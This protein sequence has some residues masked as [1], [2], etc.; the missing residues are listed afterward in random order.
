MTG[1]IVCYRVSALVHRNLPWYK[2]KTLGLP[3]HFSSII[4]SLYNQVQGKA[5]VNN[6]FTDWFPIESGVKRG[7]LLFPL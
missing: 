6:S 5:R 2:L 3:D 4:Q 7:C 1:D